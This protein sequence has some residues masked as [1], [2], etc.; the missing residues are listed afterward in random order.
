ATARCASPRNDDGTWIAFYTAVAASTDAANG[1]TIDFPSEWN[2]NGATPIG[3]AT[4]RRRASIVSGSVAETE[5]VAVASFLTG[6]QATADA[7]VTRPEGGCLP[8]PTNSLTLTANSVCPSP[9]TADGAWVASFGAHA[10]STDPTNTWDVFPDPLDW[11]PTGL[12]MISVAT[13][14]T[15]FVRYPDSQDAADITATAT[16]AN[17]PPASGGTVTARK[18]PGGC[19]PLPP[20]TNTLELSAIAECPSPLNA[21]GDWVVEYTAMASS[22][23]ATN[24]WTIDGA[25]GWFPSGS[26]SM[27]LTRPRTLSTTVD[28]SAPT[29]NLTVVASFDEGPTATASSS[30]DRPEGGCFPP[31]DNTLTITAT[32]ECASP[33]TTDGTWIATFTADAD[34]TDPTNTWTIDASVD[35]PASGWSPDGSEELGIDSDRTTISSAPGSVDRIAISAD[36][37]FT[38]GPDAS[39]EVVVSQPDGGCPPPTNAG[40]LST[41]AVCAADDPGNVVLTITLTATSDDGSNEYT[42]GATN[43]TWDPPAAGATGIDATRLAT[44]VAPADADYTATATPEFVA[45]DDVVLDTVAYEAGT[46]A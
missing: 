28:G 38:N 34:S 14:R 40:A 5:L 8:L 24:T 45:G 32:S 42:V 41:N 46:L 7:R 29:H 12:A 23:D 21:E 1:W 4:E 31:A 37:G 15:N 20:P 11:S 30:V 22:S 10:D 44:T 39:A 3:M 17:G 36:A 26:T 27:G 25:S 33:R 35:L 18:P 19:F 43:Q 13:S 16:F 2:P 6:P 9:R